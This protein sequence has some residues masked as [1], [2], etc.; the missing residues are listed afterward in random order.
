MPQYSP[1]LQRWM[2]DHVLDAGLRTYQVDRFLFVND[3]HV[4]DGSHGHDVLTGG[5]AGDLL[6]GGQGNDTLHGEA[7]NDL[8]NGGAGDDVVYGGSGNDRLQ[9]QGGNDWLY[10][11]S[12]N[13]ALYGGTGNDRLYG[14]SGD[15]FLCAGSGFDMLWGGLG[16]DTFVFRP[17]VG[18]QASQSTYMDF[19]LQEDRLR[20]DGDL[21]PGGVQRSMFGVEAD[22]DLFLTVSGGHR[23]V[24]ETLDASHLDAM[25]A[26]IEII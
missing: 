13:D 24:F 3:G 17:D 19:N 9:G 5:A 14:E 21:L 25:M 8:L 18:A 10:G 22:G 2:N 6:W 12:G 4:R 7:G 11:G 15:D 1:L 16:R 23:M 20:I 26:N